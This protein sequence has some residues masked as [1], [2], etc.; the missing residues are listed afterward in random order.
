MSDYTPP[1]PLGNDLR[2]FARQVPAT[3]RAH[4][5]RMAVLADELAEE[6]A[7]AQQESKQ[8]DL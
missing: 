7:R 1:S 6:L 2:S 3:L 5:E 4:A 8:T